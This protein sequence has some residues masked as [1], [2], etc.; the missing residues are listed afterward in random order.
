M[1]RYII[2]S[3]ND[4]P[5]YLFYTPLT[6][7]AWRKFGWEPVI[8]HHQNEISNLADE[9]FALVAEQIVGTDFNSLEDYKDYKSETITQVSRLFG[10]C[11]AEGL[12]MTGD[13]DMIPLSDYWNP[14]DYDITC[15]GRDLTD[16]HFP[17]CYIAMNTTKW[18]MIMDISSNDYNKQIAKALRHDKNIWCLDQNLITE[19]LNHYGNYYE[20][21]IK[22]ID[23]GTDK[24]TGYPIGRVDR[25]H[26][27]MQH[28][29]FID[30]HLPHDILTNDKSLYK[31]CTLL[32]HIWPE[33]DFSWFD[34]YYYEFKKLL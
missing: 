8:F 2:L 28:D 33:E 34:K 21:E 16:Y 5:K 14:G 25:S 30:A 7:W 27:T 1:N 3:T 29:V 26:W 23:R 18:E 19:K 24:R 9:R 15:Y 32:A 12:L 11:V 6:C 31:V 22:R 4:T 20:S 13:I 17:I 10:A